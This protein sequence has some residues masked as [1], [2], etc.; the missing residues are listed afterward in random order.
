MIEDSLLRLL[1][2]SLKLLFFPVPGVPIL[3]LGPVLPNCV[4]INYFISIPSPTHIP[5]SIFP[6]F[7]GSRVDVNNSLHFHKRQRRTYSSFGFKVIMHGLKE[8]GRK[9]KVDYRYQGAWGK[10]K[11][12]KRKGRTSLRKILQW[13]K[14][15]APTHSPALGAGVKN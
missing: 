13:P 4:D 1:C 10:K 6:R 5:N 3:S 7:R 15:Q 2:P 11:M 9:E 8:E 12:R 14:S